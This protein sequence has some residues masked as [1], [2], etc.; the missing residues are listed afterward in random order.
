MVTTHLH[1]GPPWTA[2]KVTR[3]TTDHENPT[4]QH[5]EAVTQEAHKAIHQRESFAILNYTPEN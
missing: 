2:A 1:P 5:G 4:V 3:V